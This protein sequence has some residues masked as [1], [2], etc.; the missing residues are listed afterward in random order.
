MLEESINPKFLKSEQKVSSSGIFSI[1]DGAG[2][3]SSVMPNMELHRVFTA[4]GADGIGQRIDFY[5]Q[6]S[7]SDLLANS[8]ISKWTTANQATRTSQFIITGVDNTTTKDL[9]YLSGA[10]LLTL[11]QGAPEYTDNAA[12]VS[13]GL[14][15]GTIYRTGDD[16]KIVH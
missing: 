16:L 9:F 3:S 4:G 7:S 13:A 15:V 11:V 1:K 14:E 5:N 12:A 8:I 10:G 6:T 2:T